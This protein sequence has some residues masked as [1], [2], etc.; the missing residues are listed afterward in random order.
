MAVD[1]NEGEVDQT[2]PENYENLLDDYS[3]FAP[4][5]ADEV[6]QGTVLSITAKDVI[7]DFGYKSEGIV[8]IEQ[9]QTRTGEITVQT[10]DVVD[11]MI[12]QGG[13]QPEVYVLLS[14]TRAARLRIWDNL[15]KAYQDQLVI[16]G[17]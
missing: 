9:F 3:H 10:G 8:P 4:P 16:S 12:D 5:A 2:V 1:H 17:H 13:E 6:L 7:I 14:H 11:V 15:E